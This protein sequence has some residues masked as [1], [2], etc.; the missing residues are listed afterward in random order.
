MDAYTRS[1]ATVINVRG[2]IRS[3]LLAASL[4]AGHCQKRSRTYRENNL[5]DYVAAVK[6]VPRPIYSHRRE[7]RNCLVRKTFVDL[8]AK[9]GRLIAPRLPKMFVDLSRLRRM[10]GTGH[11][12][13]MF[14]ELS[15]ENARKSR[16]R[17]KECC[18]STGCST[19]ARLQTRKLG[20]YIKGRTVCR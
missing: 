18:E 9:T 7:F 4:G 1:V 16:P 3:P 6:N 13:R 20:Q 19:S 12:Q 11:C 14:M 17:R 10:L 2:P 15:G 5:A 8:T